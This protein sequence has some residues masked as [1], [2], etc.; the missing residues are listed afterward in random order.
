MSLC[1]LNIGSNMIRCWRSIS[2]IN[3]QK[4]TANNNR[5]IFDRNVEYVYIL[6]STMII[7]TIEKFKESAQ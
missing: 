6:S 2:G 3:V 1:Y 5:Y 7:Y 4:H